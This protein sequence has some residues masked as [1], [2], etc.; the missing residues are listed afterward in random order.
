MMTDPIADM[1]TRIRNSASAKRVEVLIP[2]SK[3]KFTIAKIMEKMGY[4]DGIAVNEEARSF[5]V[6]LRY[7]GNTTAFENIRRV[8][9]P[10]R[11]VYAKTDE[12]KTVRSGNGIAII[13][14][15]QGLMTNL[16]ARDRKL[17]GEIICEIY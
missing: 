9:K 2:F 13:S 7:R 5:T 17:G 16:E 1:L 8:S 15:S 6:K 12:L 11:R 3:V 4:L 14:T 10:G